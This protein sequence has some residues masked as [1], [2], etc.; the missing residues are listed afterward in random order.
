MGGEDKTLD[1]TS[2][3][4]K[5][6]DKMMNH[7]HLESSCAKCNHTLINQPKENEAIAKSNDKIQAEYRIDKKKIYNFLHHG[8]SP[9]KKDGKWLGKIDPPKL[10]DLIIMCKCWRNKNASYIGGS[11]CALCVKAPCQASSTRWDSAPFVY[12][13]CAFVFT[14]K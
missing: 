10:K 6:P 8:G 11:V 14:F 9:L 13:F 3:S 5:I 1:R 4:L 2:E 7:N 12:V